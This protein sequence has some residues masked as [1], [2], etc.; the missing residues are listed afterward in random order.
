[1]CS[2]LKRPCY[3]GRNMSVL[4]NTNQ[5]PISWHVVIF[6]TSWHEKYLQLSSAGGLR[7]NFRSSIGNIAVREKLAISPCTIS[8]SSGHWYWFIKSLIVDP[9]PQWLV[10]VTNPESYF[11]SKSITN[12]MNF[13]PTDF[14]I[15]HIFSSH[16][17]III[18]LISCHN[19]YISW[20]FFQYFSAF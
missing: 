10:T 1:M 7:T 6:L 17:W 5:S 3:Y 8:R 2:A 13:L 20:T 18:K 14:P 12:L 11:C 16:S 15:T 9:N 4:I 19:P